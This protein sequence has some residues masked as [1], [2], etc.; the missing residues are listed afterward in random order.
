MDLSDRLAV[1]DVVILYAHLLDSG[2]H[3]RLA[4]EIFAPDAVLDLGSAVLSGREAIIGYLTGFSGLLGTSHNVSNFIVE[5][6]G[7][8]ARCQSH[9]LAWHWMKQPEQPD[10]PDIL[11]ADIL[12][13]GGYQDVMRRDGGRWLIE[14][15]VMLSFG[16]GLGVGT[17]SDAFKP[18]FKGMLG[19]RPDWP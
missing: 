8:R 16:T 4:A 19:R 15:R 5:I 18:L 1:Q 6:D 12:A 10:G 13:V 2:Q 14:H 11:A 3:D 17:L 7:D 9:C